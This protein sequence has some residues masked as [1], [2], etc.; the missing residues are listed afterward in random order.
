MNG[1]RFHTLDRQE[2]RNYQ[3]SGVMVRGDD[4]SDKEYYGVLMRIMFFLSSVIGTM[5]SIKEENIRLMSTE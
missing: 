5:F 1:F 2:N 3:N 4:Y